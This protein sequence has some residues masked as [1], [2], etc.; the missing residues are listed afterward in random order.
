MSDGHFNRS[1]LPHGD[2]ASG[3]RVGRASERA[4]CVEVFAEFVDRLCPLATDT[5]RQ[6]LCERF[7][8]TI[9]SREPKQ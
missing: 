5:D 4:L 1:F 2:F 3:V 6:A 7:K 9:V 8:A